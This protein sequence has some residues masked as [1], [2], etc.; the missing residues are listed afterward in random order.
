MEEL[1]TLFI[2]LA[3]SVDGL[4]SQRTFPRSWPLRNGGPTALYFFEIV[5]KSMALLCLYIMCANAEQLMSAVNTNIA[6][7]LLATTN[8]KVSQNL[9]FLRLLGND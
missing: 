7:A 6:T 2:Q 8:L 1:V 9:C 3:P 4:I 5:R